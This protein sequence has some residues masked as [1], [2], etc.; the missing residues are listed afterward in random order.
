MQ[1]KEKVHTFYRYEHKRSCNCIGHHQTDNAHIREQ[2]SNALSEEVLKFFLPCFLVPAATS[3]VWTARRLSLHVSYI[4][5]CLVDYNLY[6]EISLRFYWHF[7][8]RTL[9]FSLTSFFFLKNHYSLY[10]ITHP[11]RSWYLLGEK[12]W[13][14]IIRKRIIQQ[15]LQLLRDALLCR[16]VVDTILRFGNWRPRMF[17]SL[18]SNTKVK[19]SV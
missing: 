10:K 6:L 16:R 1:K 2:E 11:C 17:W 8:H 3:T 13:M 9:S 12:L 19:Y 7:K 18:G 4:F 15:L 5:N 14:K